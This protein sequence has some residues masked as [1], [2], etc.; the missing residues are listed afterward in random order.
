MYPVIVSR[1]EKASPRTVSTKE[2]DFETGRGHVQ[3]GFLHFFQV[4]T[5]FFFVSKSFKDYLKIFKAP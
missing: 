2:V 5:C 4:K 3:V 1:V